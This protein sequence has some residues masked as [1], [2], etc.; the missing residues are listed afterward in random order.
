MDEEN[1]IVGMIKDLKKDNAKEHAEI[2]K[3]QDITNGNILKLK[4]KQILLRGVLIGIGLVL[5]MIGF[6]PERIYILLKGIF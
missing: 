3:R 2:I 1:L 4:T 5:L 6:L